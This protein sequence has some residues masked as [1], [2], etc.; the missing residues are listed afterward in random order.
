MCACICIV[1]LYSRILRFALWCISKKNFETGTR[2]K[3]TKLRIKI[4]PHPPAYI[5]AANTVQRK[6]LRRCLRVQVRSHSSSRERAIGIG[7]TRSHLPGKRGEM[8]RFSSV[9]LILSF[10]VVCAREMIWKFQTRRTSLC[11]VLIIIAA[12]ERRQNRK[13]RERSSNSSRPLSSASS[14]GCR[15]GWENIA[16][17]LTFPSNH[18]SLSLF[19]IPIHRHVVLPP[20]IAKCLPKNR[21]LNEVRFVELRFVVFSRSFFPTVVLSAEEEEDGWC[22]LFFSSFPLCFEN[23]RRKRRREKKNR[24][25]HQNIFL[26]GFKN[27]KQQTEWRGLGVQQSRGWVHYAIHRPE[28]HIMLYRRP[29]NYGQAPLGDAN[30]WRKQKYKREIKNQNYSS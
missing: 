25:T 29:L 4:P 2:G 23:M 5:N 8:R 26:S 1:L 16:F 17:F 12:R 14:L 28:P 24:N 3:S 20:D 13:T 21:L 18:R 6:I 19:E 11:C 15:G 22:S 10:V 7:S 9:P 30:K 27:A